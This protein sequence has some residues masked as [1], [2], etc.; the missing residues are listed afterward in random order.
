MQI[1]RIR[2]DYEQRF[3]EHEHE[4]TGGRATDFAHFFTNFRRSNVDVRSTKSLTLMSVTPSLND[5]VRRRWRRD[6]FHSNV[7]GSLCSM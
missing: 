3:A 6:A 2:F 4:G 5:L 7:K 1:F